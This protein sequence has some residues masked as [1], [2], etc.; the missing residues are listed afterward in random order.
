MKIF[1]V[2]Q[3]KLAENFSVMDSFIQKFT[4]LTKQELKS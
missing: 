1:K 4:F 3:K 2:T